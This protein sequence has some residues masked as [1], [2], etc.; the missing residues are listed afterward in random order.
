M[1]EQAERRVDLGHVDP[2]ERQGVQSDGVGG[3]RLV[4][5]DGSEEFRLHLVDGDRGQALLR[6]GTGG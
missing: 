3:K 5:G 4:Q 2:E 1:S 6:A